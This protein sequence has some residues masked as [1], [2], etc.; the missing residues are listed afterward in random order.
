MNKISIECVKQKTGGYWL[1]IKS[2]TKAVYNGLTSAP[3]VTTSN[4][5]QNLILTLKY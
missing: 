4:V 1:T 3:R 5:L 2:G